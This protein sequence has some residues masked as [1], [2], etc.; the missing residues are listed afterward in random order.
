MILG[1]KNH[2]PKS[3]PVGLGEWLEIRGLEGW[4]EIATEGLAG[5]ARRRIRREIESHFS[6]AVSSHVEAGLAES[7]AQTTALNEL[8]NP[9]D[10]ARRFRKYYLTE[11]ESNRLEW[12]VRFA[13][14][15]FLS[16]WLLPFDIIAL[17]VLFAAFETRNNLVL[18][19]LFSALVFYSGVRVF[20]RL[21]S[22]FVKRREV[23]LRALAFSI[24]MFELAQAAC[25]ALPLYWVTNSF[26]SLLPLFINPNHIRMSRIWIKLRRSKGDIYWMPPKHLPSS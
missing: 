4:L 21:L 18:S 26:I 6:E 1:F 10:A 9:Q 19:I 25:F 16:W 7:T 5:P 8:G 11:A 20:P 3:R 12:W 24:L 15:P 23:F 13:D 17:G 2:F 22:H 14:R